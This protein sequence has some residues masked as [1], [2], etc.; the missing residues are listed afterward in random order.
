MHMKIRMN[1]TPD[2]GSVLLVTLLTATIIAICLASYLTVVS[3]QHRST[4]RSLAWNSC[5]PVLEAGIEEA[6]TQIHYHGI[7]NLTAN[8]WTVGSDGRY[9]KTRSIGDDG[10]Y[11]QVAIEPVNPPVIISEGFVPAPFS[12]SAQLGMIQSPSQIA[13]NYVSRRV[14]VNTI[15][16]GMFSQA[17]L[18]K[19][20]ISFSGSARTDSFDSTKSSLNTNGKY[21]PLKTS[22]KGDVA[23]NGTVASTFVGSGTI[24]LNGH[25]STGPGGAFDLNGTASIGSTAWHQAGN[26][27]VEKDWAT[28]DM[29]VDIPDVDVPFTSGDSTAVSETIDG[30]RYD[31][32]FHSGNYKLS[33]F[34]L[35]NSQKAIITGD[36]VLYVTDKMSVSGSAQI[37]IAPGAKL[38][39][40]SGAATAS[41]SGNGVANQTGNAANFMYFGLPTNTRLDMSG[42]SGGFMGVI[43]APNAD[44]N[45]SG[46]ADSDLINFTGASVSKT[47]NMSGGRSFHYDE[48]LASLFQ[49]FVVVAWNE[50]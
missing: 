38:K 44:L 30:V 47:V 5:I 23:S 33:N 3:H 43:Y 9:H 45:L 39:I 12:A 36:A 42:A 28:D 17:M 13:A 10:T 37:I 26:S 19:G 1:E 48:S 11:Y 40:Y 6:L 41:I 32:A 4:A 31:Y 35:F 7:T 15:A 22:D 25:L 46:G 14:Q 34:L 29:N 2:Q 21:D 20:N 18:A 24:S 8:G 27:G 49:S 50:I 16:K